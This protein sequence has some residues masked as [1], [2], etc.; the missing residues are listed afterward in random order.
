MLL[1]SQLFLMHWWPLDPWACSGSGREELQL[2]WL[3]IC[4]DCHGGWD[5]SL[6]GLCSLRKIFLLLLW[7]QTVLSPVSENNS[8]FLGEGDGERKR[9]REREREREKKI[10]S[11]SQE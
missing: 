10:L 8:M 6:Y 1:F 2:F 11:I 9:G 7:I 4:R 5:N 3:I